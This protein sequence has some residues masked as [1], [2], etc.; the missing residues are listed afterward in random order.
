MVKYA[1]GQMSKEQLEQTMADFEEKKIQ[2]PSMY[3]D[4]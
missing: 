2:C 1:H 3:H 4:Y